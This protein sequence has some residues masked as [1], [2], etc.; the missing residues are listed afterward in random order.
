MVQGS[1]LSGGVLLAGL[2]SRCLGEVT[3][4]LKVTATFLLS[5][6]FIRN[7]LLSARSPLPVQRRH[8][9]LTFSIFL[10]PLQ[11]VLFGDRIYN[12]KKQVPQ[13][14]IKFTGLSDRQLKHLFK[15]ENQL[16]KAGISFDTGYDFQEKCR[17]WEFDWSL[18]GATVE[19]KEGEKNR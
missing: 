11:E 5:E 1:G 6:E 9:C 3:S 12:M 15:A 4:R 8:T 16:L 18:E 13:V 10:L 2:T 7:Y 14:R 19:I 17:D